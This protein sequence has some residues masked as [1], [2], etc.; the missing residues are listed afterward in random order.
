M[1]AAGGVSSESSVL[2]SPLSYLIGYKPDGDLKYINKGSGRSVE[3]IAVDPA[4]KKI[5]VSGLKA[6]IIEVR[7]VSALTRQSSGVYKYQSVKKE[8]PVSLA[9]LAISAQGRKFSLPT[10][11][12]GDFLL[13]VKD[14]KN[15]E[16]NRIAFSVAGKGNLTRSLEKNA[17]LQ[18]KLNKSDFAPGEEI[19]MHI[20]A[21]YT[22][23]GLITIERDR[24]YA[25]QWF[26]TS[27]TSSVQRIRVPANFEGNGYV[28]VSFV[29]A[30]D[31]PEIFMSP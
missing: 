28:N 6:Q 19:E 31:S 27:S 12:P 1:K 13:M 20:R 3:L 16:L 15:V 9:D 17:E 30:I 11:N 23:A 5:S 14:E 18:I 21:P 24:V 7:Y 10:G 22:G 8:I 25:S 29:R 26:K 2:V 4:L